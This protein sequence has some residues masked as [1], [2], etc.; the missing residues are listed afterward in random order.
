VSILK[1]KERGLGIVLAAIHSTSSFCLLLYI[2]TEVEADDRGILRR[3]ED[4]ISSEIRYSLIKIYFALSFGFLII[5][6][7]CVISA[8]NHTYLLFWLLS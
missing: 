1:Q 4:R 8:H 5:E 2:T 7:I 6:V 3:L